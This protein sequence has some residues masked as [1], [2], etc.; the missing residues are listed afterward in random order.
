ME[1][2]IRFDFIQKWIKSGVN[3]ICIYIICLH[4]IEN[5]VYVDNFLGLTPTSLISIFQF[6][7]HFINKQYFIL[8]DTGYDPSR[9]AILSTEIS[10]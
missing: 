1:K 6:F 5:L 10:P 3:C 2:M 7:C 4:E 9:Q 8:G